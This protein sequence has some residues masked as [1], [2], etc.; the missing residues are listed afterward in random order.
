MGD[1]RMNAEAEPAEPEPTWYARSTPRRL[2]GNIYV[3]VLASLGYLGL[4][5]TPL[6]IIL[7]DRNRSMKDWVMTGP[8]LAWA[9]VVSLAYP[10]WCWAEAR[11]FE[12]W[13]RLQPAAARLRERAYFKLQADLAKNF[14]TSV[15][16]VYTIAGLWSIAT[17]P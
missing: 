13:V 10:V 16:A 2:F 5:A 11:A 9:A 4:A 17:R 15:L 8:G 6:F 1:P 3:H 14:W 12:R 7:L